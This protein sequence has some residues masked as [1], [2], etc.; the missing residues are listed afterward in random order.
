MSSSTAMLLFAA[1][2]IIVSS[3]SR[4][5]AIRTEAWFLSTLPVP[6]GSL[7][8]SVCGTSGRRI[9]LMPMPLISCIVCWMVRP[10]PAPPFAQKVLPMY[11]SIGAPLGLV[12]SLEGSCRPSR[13][14]QFPQRTGNT[15][16]LRVMRPAVFTRNTAPLAPIVNGTAAV[17]VLNV[18]LPLSNAVAVAVWLPAARPVAVKL[19]GEVVSLDTSALSTRNSTRMTEPPGSAAVADN[20]TAA[21][22]ANAWPLVGAVS[23]TVGAVLPVLAIVNG[24]AAE[25]VLSAGLPLSTA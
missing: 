15:V 11:C 7:A 16:P 25:T 17:A 21:P 20:V 5:L 4:E 6:C 18:G 1:A 12:A 8:F 23:V 13:P 9:M 3:A 24:T 14:N 22:A 2:V 19:Y 10:V